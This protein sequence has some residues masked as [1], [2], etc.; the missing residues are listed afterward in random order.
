MNEIE[1]SIVANERLHEA[2]T[3]ARP[4]ESDPD[5]PYAPIPPERDP[6]AHVEEQI[7]RL[8]EA[9]SRPGAPVVPPAAPPISIFESDAEYV[10]LV[11][12]PGVTRE[13]LD[14]QLR[15]DT[16]IVN[17]RRDDPR[18]EGLHARVAERRSGAFQRAIRLPADARAADMLARL[19]A[20]V[21]EIR[22]PRSAGSSRSVPVA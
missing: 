2:L 19:E 12:V 4:P 16:V 22:I 5:V 10:V 7:D 3:G 1:E 18:A 20:G 14:V 11:D 8:L 6:V 9:L 13:R 15:G 21:L 17:G